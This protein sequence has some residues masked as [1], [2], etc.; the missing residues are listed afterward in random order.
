MASLLRIVRFT[1]ALAPLYTAIILCSV[2]TA[3]A[4]LAVPFLIG[5]ATDTVAGAVGGQ[6]PTGTAVRAVVLIAAAVLVAEL[7]NTV[8]SNIGG[9]YGDV[10][11]NR[12]RT[13]L[14]VRYY[15]KLLHLP[16]RWFDG[17]ITGTIVARLNRSITEITNFAKMMSNSFASMLITTVA[18]LAISAWYAWPLTVL[19]L[20]VFPLYVWLTSL[21]SVKWQRLEGEKN[22]Q[23]DIASGRFAEVVGQIRVVKSFVRERSELEDFRRRFWSTDATTRAQSTHWHRMDVIRRAVL[24]LV[25]FGIYVIIFVRTVQGAF[26]L[27]EMVLLVQLMSM[28]KAPVESMSWVI[29]SSQRAI[30]G[31]KDYFR[32]MGTEVDPRT[33]AMLARAE[34]DV[35]P[36]AIEPVPGAPVVRFRDVSFA[37]EDGEDVLHGIDFSVARG[38]KIAL[39]GESGGGK[40]TIVNLL[41]GLY[42]PR[43]GEIEVVG[44]TSTEL[45]LDELRSRIGVVFQDASLFSG[46]LRENIAYGRPGASDEE[47]ADAARRAN[48]DGFVRRFPGGYEQVIGERGLKLSGGQRQRIAVARAILKDAPVLV[49]DEAT[50]ALDTKAERQV[51]KGLDELMEG[52]TSLIIA[53]RLSTIAAVDRIITLEDGRID[54]IGT[55]AELAASGGIYAQLLDLQN[56]GDRKRL[57]RFDITG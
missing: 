2:L 30:A 11:S 39:V 17:E 50:S 28:A 47:V 21:T 56:S 53:H 9:W 43:A 7:F 52:R 48:A 20:I 26:T 25:F 41:L 42:E 36:P 23:V 5:H 31:S 4:A 15:D 8:V 14:S 40:S 12:M 10:M 45:P 27:G 22:E 6:T 44:R 35:P 19:L 55:P 16:Q 49:L 29:D 32:V 37:Y 1:R 18:V 51:Q 24:N 13:I 46:T 33:A 54:E 34:D 3:A 38:E 57:A